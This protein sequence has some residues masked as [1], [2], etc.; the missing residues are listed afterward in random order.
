MVKPAPKT[1][2]VAIC[3]DSVDMPIVARYGKAEFHRSRADVFYE[4]GF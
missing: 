4:K 1:N 3:S 2:R